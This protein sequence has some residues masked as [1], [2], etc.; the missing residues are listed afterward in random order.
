VQ[1]GIPGL[2][3]SIRYGG[4]VVSGKEPAWIRSGIPAVRADCGA[5]S[6]RGDTRRYN[7]SGEYL[8]GDLRKRYLRAAVTQYLLSAQFSAFAT[9]S[10][11]TP[12][13]RAMASLLS[14]N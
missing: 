4:A 7:G 12:I 6:A 9:V 5:G 3:A 11:S 13:C 14:P 8:S 2:L 1:Q 10:P